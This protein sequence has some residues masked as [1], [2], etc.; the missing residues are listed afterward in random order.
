M[1]SLTTGVLKKDDKYAT[2]LKD[3]TKTELISLFL[4][5]YLHYAL[6]L[7]VHYLHRP[8]MYIIRTGLKF[9]RRMFPRL[10]FLRECSPSTPWFASEKPFNEQCIQC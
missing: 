6:L 9:V 2:P 10:I 5:V 1:F 7:Y 4:L 8:C 3:V